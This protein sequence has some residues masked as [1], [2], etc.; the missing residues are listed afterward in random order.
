MKYL[1]QLIT[2]IMRHFFNLLIF[3]PTNIVIFIWHLDTKHF[4]S[5]SSI[6]KGWDE[7][8]EEVIKDDGFEGY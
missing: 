2:F 1:H 6:M 3:L 7:F 8:Y 5:Y 4:I